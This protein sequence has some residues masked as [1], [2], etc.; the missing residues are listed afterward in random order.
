MLPKRLVRKKFHLY[1]GMGGWRVAK[2]G[3]M[4]RYFYSRAKARVYMAKL[5][6]RIK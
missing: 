4:G 5:N 6:A 3:T 2:D 1:R